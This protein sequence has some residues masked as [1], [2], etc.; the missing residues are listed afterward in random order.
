[1]S[2]SEFALPAV[3]GKKG[4]NKAGR[5]AYPIPNESHARAAVRDS[6]HAENVGNISAGERKEI[7]R[8]VHAKFPS[9]KVGSMSRPGDSNRSGESR[10]Q[11]AERLDKWAA[12]GK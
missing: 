1:M 2:K 6:K 12:G 10:H 8:K 11:R 4:E 3:K 9:I 5:G 7:L